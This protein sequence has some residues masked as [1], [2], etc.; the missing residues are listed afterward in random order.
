M[1][2]TG[3]AETEARQPDPAAAAEAFNEAAEEA[4]AAFKGKLSQRY[5]EKAAEAE[6]AAEALEADTCAEGGQE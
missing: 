1:I 5:F 3:D 4:A 2:T 6:A